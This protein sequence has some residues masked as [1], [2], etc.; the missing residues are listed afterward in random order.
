Q[1]RGYQ[2]G[3]Q[4]AQVVVVTGTQ[5]DIGFQRQAD[6]AFDAVSDWDYGIRGQAEPRFQKDVFLAQ[7]H[8]K[9]AHLTVRKQAQELGYTIEEERVLSNGEI[10]LV[11]AV[12]Q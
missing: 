9:C 4:R 3:T 8:Q 6:Q 5:Y 12:P 2:G 11:V 7:V 10:E 1:V